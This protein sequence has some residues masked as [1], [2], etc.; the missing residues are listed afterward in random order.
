VA[1]PLSLVN[2]LSL[3]AFNTLYFRRQRR[4]RVASQVHYQPFF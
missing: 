3:P 4:D 2:G 1:P